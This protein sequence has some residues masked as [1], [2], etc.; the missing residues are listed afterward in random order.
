MDQLIWRQHFVPQFYLDAWVDP[1]LPTSANRELWRV[2]LRYGDI[3]HASPESVGY[4]RY[5]NE[6]SD[7][8]RGTRSLEKEYGCHERA[9]APVLKAIGAGCSTLNDHQREALMRFLALQMARTPI[10]REYMAQHLQSLGLSPAHDDV[11]DACYEEA[12][13][14]VTQRLMMAKWSGCVAREPVF[15]T[16]DH[17]AALIREQ[18][19]RRPEWHL[20]FPVTPS[21][22]LLGCLTPINC[23]ERHAVHHADEHMLNKTVVA[24][25]R[26]QIYTHRR[27]AAEDA[28]SVVTRLQSEERNRLLFLLR[29]RIGLAHARQ[30][31]T[32]A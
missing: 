26:R 17:P 22:L 14:R 28:L 6:Y 2:D 32:R 20:V 25:A 19:A 16:C 7:K 4:E 8:F 23:R 29:T 11:L 15:V 5:H 24:C 1:T 27:T 18:D 9:A 31:P 21:V 12:L 3:K 13:G 10:G 30:L